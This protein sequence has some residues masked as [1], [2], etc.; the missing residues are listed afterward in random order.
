MN[1]YRDFRGILKQ[2]DYETRLEVKHLRCELIKAEYSSRHPKV[3]WN[4]CRRG[5]RQLFRSVA[6]GAS[7]V[8]RY[9]YV[10]ARAL[11]RDVITRAVA[12]SIKSGRRL[13][14]PF[15]SF[16]AFIITQKYFFVKCFVTVFENS[17]SIVQTRLELVRISRRPFLKEVRL[18]LPT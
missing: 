5:R 4:S 13:S 8:P 12:C 9:L 16:C 15:F 18:P 6:E 10:I 7:I 3:N 1:T 11:R 14:I 17:L 2:I